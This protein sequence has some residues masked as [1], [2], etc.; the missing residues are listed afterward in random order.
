MIS[1]IEQVEAQIKAGQGI[2]WYSLKDKERLE[3]YLEKLKGELNN[4]C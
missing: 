2:G 4:G 3:S 1:L